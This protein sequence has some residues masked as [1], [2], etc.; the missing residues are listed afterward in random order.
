MNLFP[1]PRKGAGTGKAK[2]SGAGGKFTWGSML[3]DGD[4]GSEALD[5]NDPNYN[6]GGWL[7]VGLLTGLTGRG[8]QGAAPQRPQLP[9][10]WVGW[11]L[12]VSETM[13]TQG[14]G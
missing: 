6:S 11:D 5:R 14:V 13:R 2:K 4:E 10:G 1:L 9:L 3:T 12:E 8:Q 7:V